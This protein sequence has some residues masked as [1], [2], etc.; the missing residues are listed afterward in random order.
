MNAT[1]T[2][3]L[4]APAL[5]ALL[6]CAAPARADAVADLTAL[7][8][9]AS[10]NSNPVMAFMRGLARMGNFELKTADVRRALAAA[11]LPPGG[12]LQQV[13]GPTTN[14][15]KSGDRI[16][17]E[18]SQATRVTMPN[19]A[20]VELGRRIKARFRVHNE[21]DASIDD[22]SGIKVAEAAN[23]TYYDLWDVKFTRENGKPVA[24]ITAGALIFSK[25]LTVDL[26]DIK[27]VTPPPSNTDPVTS[28]T[29]QP[30]VNSTPGLV[31]LGQGSHTVVAGDTLYNIAKRHNIT[32]AALK[33]ANN[34]TSDT[35]SLGATLRIPPA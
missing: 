15:K 6:L 4:F 12:I 18:R 34:L 27:P 22:I 11:N 9:T 23:G 21:H 25:T 5:L 26:S 31:A 3:S 19:G 24:K 29:P 33:A 28:N 7:V 30:P 35:V 2:R 17:I 8:K 10:T 32:V 1:A 14:L 13:L 16:E 20:G